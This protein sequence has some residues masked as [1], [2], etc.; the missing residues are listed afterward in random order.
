MG[1]AVKPEADNEDDEEEL[2]DSD[3]IVLDSIQQTAKKQNTMVKRPCVDK[4]RK[5]VKPKEG[6][7]HV[8]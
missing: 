4:E 3:V 8:V 7:R 2:R 6:R 5:Y 1:V